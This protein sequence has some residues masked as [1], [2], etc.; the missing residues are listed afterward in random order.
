[1]PNLVPSASYFTLAL[2]KTPVTLMTQRCSQKPAV[3]A[4]KIP[5][6]PP[7]TLKEPPE[8]VQKSL[9]DCLSLDG[10]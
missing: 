7:A 2:Q 9:L 5:K 1:M 3:K 4:R 10:K 6:Q 8:Q